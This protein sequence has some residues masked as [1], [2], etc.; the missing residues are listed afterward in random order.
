MLFISLT[1]SS[2]SSTLQKN[3]VSSPAANLEADTSLRGKFPGDQHSTAGD[4]HSIAI[5]RHSTASDNHST[6]IDQHSTTRDQH[7]AAGDNENDDPPIDV[8][9]RIHQFNE[10][11]SKSATDGDTK[12]SQE[13]SEPPTDVATTAD[14]SSSESSYMSLLC[15]NKNLNSCFHET[16]NCILEKL[17]VPVEIGSLDNAGSDK[18]SETV[19]CTI[20]S[21]ENSGDILQSSCKLLV[22]DDSTRAIDE[23]ISSIDDTIEIPDNDL[24]KK[25]LIEIFV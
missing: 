9:T 10:K 2:N 11:F 5:D 14:D 25:V 24:Q 22:G 15:D 12:R 13:F 16:S 7:S 8:A 1:D 18:V 23:P 20:V 17:S 19:T 4:Q 21:N 3:G 6:D